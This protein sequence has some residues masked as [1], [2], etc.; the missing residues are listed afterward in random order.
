[1][2]LIYAD[3]DKLRIT[4]GMAA[5][6]VSGEIDKETASQQSEALMAMIRLQQETNRL[7]LD[8]LANISVT[9][10][11]AHD[12]GTME[13]DK[14]SPLTCAK[15]WF[16]AM[17]GLACYTPDPKPDELTRSMFASFVK[18]VANWSDAKL[19]RKRAEF[20]FELAE[21]WGDDELGALPA[22]VGI[23]AQAV[24]NETGILIT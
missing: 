19:K 12:F 9:R 15:L 6:P 10:K 16:G 3:D 22:F 7:C 2:N 14:I 18:D 13:G 24:G 5:I 17:V 21:Y 4:G 8:K 23:L 1:V 20:N 11:E